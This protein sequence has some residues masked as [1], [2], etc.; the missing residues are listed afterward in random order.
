MMKPRNFLAATLLAVVPLVS[1][2]TTYDPD[3]PTASSTALAPPPGVVIEPAQPPAVVQPQTPPAPGVVVQ[4]PSGVVAGQPNQTVQADQINAGEV[5]AQAIYA[6]K[7]E[8]SDVRG[9][10]HKVERVKF[11]SKRG[12]LRM[13]S[14]LAGAIYADRIVANTVTADHIYVRDL[15][16]R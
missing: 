7:I 16:R 12:D 2:C 15:E 14:L 11:D 4:Q 9:V 3:V 13:P 1:A 6:N 8:A 10:V 5:R